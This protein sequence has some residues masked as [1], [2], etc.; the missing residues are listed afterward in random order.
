MTVL[1]D[2]W[3][4]NHSTAL[5]VI[6]SSLCTL[7][8]RLTF[9]FLKMATFY[10]VPF[11]QLF[12]N[13]LLKAGIP[14]YYNF[15][16]VRQSLIHCILYVFYTVVYAM[17][18]HPNNQNLFSMPVA[19]RDIHLFIYIY[20]PVLQSVKLCLEKVLLY[21]PAFLGNNMIWFVPS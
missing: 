20:L 14:E 17:L 21:P 7:F 5:H 1:P 15:L 8:G 16:N 6:P 2:I 9:V 12:S 19:R 4:E 13:F 3:N 18:I 10:I 11:K